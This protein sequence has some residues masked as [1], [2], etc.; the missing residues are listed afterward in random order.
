MK[1]TLDKMRRV[2]GGN[3][4][5]NELAG[6]SGINEINAEQLNAIEN[7]DVNTGPDNDQNSDNEA[8]VEMERG[9]ARNRN[10]DETESIVSGSSIASALQAKHVA[11]TKANPLGKMLLNMAA[12]NLAL[13]EKTGITES[14][15]NAAELCSAFFQQMEMERKNVRKELTKIAEK[16]EEKIMSR[17]F[18]ALCVTGVESIPDYFSKRSKLTSNAAKVEALRIFPFKH[19]FS[20][21]GSGDTFTISEFFSS[22]KAAQKQMRLTEPEYIHMLLMCTSGKAHELIQ[23]WVDQEEGLN[24]IY[25][26]MMLQYDRRITPDAARLKLANLMATKNVD[27]PRHISNVMSLADRASYALPQGASRAAYY[28]NEAIQ[29]LIRSLPPTSRNVCSN[30]FHTLSA[31]ARRAITFMELSRP[32]NALRHTIDADI[33]QNGAGVVNTNKPPTAQGKHKKGK[34]KGYTSY[35][36]DTVLE[37]NDTQSDKQGSKRAHTK[38]KQVNGSNGSS[39]VVYQNNVQQAGNTKGNPNMRGNPGKQKQHTS[40][41]PNQNNTKRYC[42]LCGKTNHTAAQGCRNMKDNN[43]QVVTVQPA[44]STCNVCPATVVPR[45]NHPPF[46]CPFRPTGPLHGTR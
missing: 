4:S 33:K 38:Q 30:M 23:Q 26:N 5:D 20:G 24:N 36:I 39:A 11:Y 28:N 19:K 29:A 43:G 21:N 22:M 3:Q 31:K 34:G 13:Q 10:R 42:S 37:D 12:D 46:L 17:E 1:K 14:N 15:V 6:P 41:I 40:N 45:L 8:G 16:T 32:L 27:L 7:W 44:Q 25:F 9:R 18:D 35:A 2:S